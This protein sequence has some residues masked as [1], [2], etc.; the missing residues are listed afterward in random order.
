MKKNIFTIFL[1]TLLTMTC[2]EKISISP[3]FTSETDWA[4]E[5]TS[6]TSGYGRMYLYF[7][8][9]PRLELYRAIEKYELA[10]K[11]DTE[12]TYVPLETK[13]L[14]TSTYFQTD[15]ILTTD[16]IYQA[17]VSVHYW[18]EEVRHSN[19]ISFYSPAVKGR[20][21]KTI[22][23]PDSDIFVNDIALD[24]TFGNGGIYATFLS[25]KA[26]F[27]DTL[28][29]DVTYISTEDY[30][31]VHV[32]DNSDLVLTEYELDESRFRLD[33]Y[34]S[35]TLEI[36][37]SKHIVIPP[38]P[39]RD[40]FFIPYRLH[41]YYY[42][43]GDVIYLWAGISD[44]ELLVKFD[45]NNNTV[46]EVSPPFPFNYSTMVLEPAEDQIWT[47]NTSALYDNRLSLISFDNPEVPSEEYYSPVAGS[48]YF[49][50]V[51]DYFWAYD[52]Y[53]GALVKYLPEAVE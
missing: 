18:N 26:V 2:T 45:I 30:R 22:P 14:Y 39:Y 28:N 53:K 13:S 34:N 5:L 17:R 31:S 35:V 44:G 42:D 12:S 36:D 51:D 1:L 49:V 4:P 10:I 3:E 47:N 6:I 38:F 48:A 24:L 9:P 11:K 20:I 29:G 41:S 40:G 27:I 19:E 21:F 16:Q 32:L 7:D 50:P 8:I 25:R 37:S 15:S 43:G 46:Q 23:L 33:Y 52:W